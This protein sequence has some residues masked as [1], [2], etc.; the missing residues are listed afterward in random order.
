[1]QISL[2]STERGFYSS[3]PG[4]PSAA[5][6]CSHRGP[7][8]KREKLLILWLIGRQSR[9][10]KDIC[11]LAQMLTNPNLSFSIVSFSPCNFSSLP[12]WREKET[13]TDFLHLHDLEW[14]S[15]AWQSPSWGF[16]GGQGCWPSTFSRHP[17]HTGTIL[18][19]CLYTD[20]A[21]IARVYT[22]KHLPTIP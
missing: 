14:A 19:D 18:M 9:A 17:V 7:S 16:T 5:F 22:P 8:G 4:V 21:V 2:R 13:R 3:G 10:N 12:L 6:V 15:W 11:F 1:M 20:S